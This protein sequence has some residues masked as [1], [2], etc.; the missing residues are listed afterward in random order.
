[1]EKLPSLLQVS[2]RQF[3][4]RGIGMLGTLTT[5]E[6]KGLLESEKRLKAARPWVPALDG[7]FDPGSG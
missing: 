5:E 7:E 4:A 6:W 2:E 3:G 1:M